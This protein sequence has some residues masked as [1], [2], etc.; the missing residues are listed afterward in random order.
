M[1]IAD[2]PPASNPPL[3]S[4]AR[5]QRGA[6]AHALR[7]YQRHFKRALDVALIVA[8]VPVALPVIAVCAALVATDGHA[9]LYRQRRVGLNGKVFQIVKLRSMVPQAEAALTA[10]LDESPEA[11]AEWDS[12]QKLRQ[13]P[14]VTRIGRILR[15]TSL[16]ELPQLWNVLA[17]DM[18]LV[19]PRP[20]MES[21]R[22]LY[23]GTAYFLMRP[24]ITGL[25]Q[26]SARNLSE[27]A[28][29]SRFDAEYWHDLSLTS[30]LRIL[31]RTIGVVLRSTGC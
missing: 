30:D 6:R 26:I 15:K 31:W 1:S 7:L 14:R 11:R 16:D 20:M 4:A 8:A 18:S 2:L 17:G 3:R 29:R 13:D 25:W 21:Q 19:G 28:D 10:H 22:P 24:G 5:V 23:P 27:F 12:F 9:P